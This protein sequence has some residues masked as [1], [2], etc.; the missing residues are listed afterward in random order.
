RRA[1]STAYL[2]ILNRLPNA[3]GAGRNREP[4]EHQI[5][6][7]NL[8]RRQSLGHIGEPTDYSGDLSCFS[9][10]E[11]Q[12]C[13]RSIGILAREVIQLSLAVIVDDNY[14]TVSTQSLDLEFPA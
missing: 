3:C 1:G 9:I 8:S 14:Q 5:L 12:H 6:Q 4:F 2:K 10:T 13:C 11:R 7:N